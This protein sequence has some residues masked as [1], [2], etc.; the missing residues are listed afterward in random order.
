VG[1]SGHGKS[2]DYDIF[3]K[4]PRK[5]SIRNRIFYTPSVKKLGFVNY[6]MS[7]IDLIG[8]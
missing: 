3:Y 2:R 7:Y 8:R 4:K 6:R 1:Q 5:L